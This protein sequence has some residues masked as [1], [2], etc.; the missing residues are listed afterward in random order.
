MND[1]VVAYLTQPTLVERSKGNSYKNTSKRDKK[2]RHARLVITLISQEQILDC[3]LS[4]LG[5]VKFRGIPDHNY[6][7]SN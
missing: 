2:I 4:F 1:L 6:T 3:V 5:F 7:F